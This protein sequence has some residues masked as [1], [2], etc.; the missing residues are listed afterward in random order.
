MSGRG[1][2]E[3][4]GGVE[5]R[6]STGD[7]TGRRWVRL[8]STGRTLGTI[9]PIGKCWDW[10]PSPSA[11]RG[12]G[13][14]GHERDGDPTD[15]VPSELLTADTPQRLRLRHEACAALVE[16]LWRR[17]A[18]VLGFGPHLLVTPAGPDLLGDLKRLRDDPPQ[19][20]P[21][22]YIVSP[23]AAAWLRDRGL[24]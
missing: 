4:V 20:K 10:A 15:R 18:P 13:R 5:L 22:Y 11:F 3:T 24:A 7:R 9:V 19:R 14:R 23:R 2:R 6:L 12:D 17:R 21:D 16:C 8:A 1:V